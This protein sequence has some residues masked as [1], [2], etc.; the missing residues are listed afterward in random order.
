M[1][2]CETR[3]AWTE[4]KKEYY[5]VVIKKAGSLRYQPFLFAKQRFFAMI[6]K[7]IKTISRV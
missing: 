5:L 4:Q 6:E 3:Q 2:L 7:V 1:S